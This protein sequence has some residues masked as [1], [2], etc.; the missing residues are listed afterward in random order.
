[1][2]G[3][4]PIGSVPRIR[5][6]VLVSLA[7]IATM[8]LEFA[9]AQG[10]AGSAAAVEPRY[11][12]DIP[13]AGITSRG[14][15]ALDM[16][17]YQSGGVLAELSIG[18][19]DRMIVGA[20]YG[21]VNVLGTE[22]PLWNKNAGFDV[23]IRLI[24]ETVPLPAIALGFNSQGRELHIDELNRY[25]IKSLGFFAV[26]SKNYRAWGSLSLHGGVNYSLERDDDSAPN[27]FGG[28]DKSLGP[29]A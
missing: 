1:M 23:K 29:F 2:P 28:I 7:L 6:C 25:S 15:L 26:V 17:F 12:I 11:L 3:L 20:S 14:T 27:I 9:D 4:A 19:F 13:T 18:L 8:S 24:E 21:G 10:S 5:Q 16:D 22:K